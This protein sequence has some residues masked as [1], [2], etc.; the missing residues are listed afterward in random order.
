MFWCL[1]TVK[2]SNGV[3]FATKKGEGIICYLE[4]Y[5]GS[6][7]SSRLGTIVGVSLAMGTEV[8]CIQDIRNYLVKNQNSV[9]MP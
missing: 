8:Y 4:Y 7:D 6:Y 1:F 9:S 5:Y 2:F 3:I